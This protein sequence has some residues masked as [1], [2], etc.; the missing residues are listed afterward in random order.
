MTHIGSTV[1]S[2]VDAGTY[3]QVADWIFGGGPKTYAV[4][5]RPFLY[6][7]M[8]GTLD[9]IGGAGAV[10]LLNF[11]LWIAAL[12]ITGLTVYRFVKRSW[13]AAIVFAVMATNI[14][15]IVLTFHALAETLAVALLA[16]WA[17]GLTHLSIRIT[18]A[19]AAWAVLPLALLTIAKPEFELVLGVTAVAVLVLALRSPAPA[20]IVAVVT[21][22]LVPVAAQVALMA[23]VNH[24][25]GLS[26]VGDDTLR[27]YY[28]ARLYAVIAHSDDIVG[29]RARTEGLATMTLL[30]VTAA[31]PLETVWVLASTLKDNLLSGSNFVG[32]S[33]P[34][35]AGAIVVTNYV[36][37]IALAALVPLAAIAISAGR[38]GRLVLLCAGILNILVTGSLS[39]WQGDRLTVI[40]LPLWLVALALAASQAA[41]RLA[42]LSQGRRAMPPKVG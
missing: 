37:A 3:R 25:A 14:S 20:A 11:L 36:Y 22:C 13:A 19:Q 39:F 24:Y 7:L 35:L 42:R 21:V 5:E 15:L 18:P 32:G 26:V 1:F 34:T 29:Q 33:N 17:Y 12:N 8:L 23:T 10:W 30:R 27:A 40:A 2:S 31:H 28:G 16:L 38:D 41:P 6:P 9:R 4:A